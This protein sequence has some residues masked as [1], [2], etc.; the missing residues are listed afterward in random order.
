MEVQSDFR[1]LFK[2]FNASQVGNIATW[3]N[4][5]QPLNFKLLVRAI[6]SPLATA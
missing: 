1:E 6:V 4:L 3:I 2:L 5:T